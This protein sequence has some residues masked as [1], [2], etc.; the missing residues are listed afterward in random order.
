MSSTSQRAGDGDIL[1]EEADE[2]EPEAVAETESA[3]ESEADSQSVADLPLDHVFEILKNERRRT[4]L[5]YLQDHG[6]TVSLGE[7]A[8]HVAA[9]ENGT[10]VA[11]VT[12]NERKCVY[13]GLY[14]CHLPKMDDMDIVEFNQNRGRISL[15]PNA[16][17]LYE[18]LEESD[19]LDRPWPLYYGS[20]TGAGVL[21]LVA[22]QLGAAA[23]GLT[24]TVVA[25]V[26]L[27]GVVGVSAAQTLDRRDEE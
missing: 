14:Q 27:V 1:A 15:G 13:V 8:E 10:T 7:L 18:Y 25:T 11:Q 9:V 16:A 22:S 2:P 12:S 3:P 23:V 21:G 19:D 6:G 20:L 4:V 26:V 5:H 17:Q 24:P